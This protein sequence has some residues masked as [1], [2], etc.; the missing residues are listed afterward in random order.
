MNTKPSIIRI[1]GALVIAVGSLVWLGSCAARPN[2]IA[3]GTY[4]LAIEP[5]LQSAVDR[6]TAMRIEG[7]LTVAGRISSTAGVR[8]VCPGRIRIDLIDPRGRMIDSRAVTY[9]SRNCY[10]YYYIAR[11]ARHLRYHHPGRF[12]VI[13]WTLPPAGTTMEIKRSE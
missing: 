2:L 11:S 4:A 3:D 6:M 12:S 10:S 1:L 8:T 9:Y 13:F 7:T 5:E